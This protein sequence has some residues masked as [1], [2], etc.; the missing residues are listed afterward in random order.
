M[1]F[2]TLT[3]LAILSILPTKS[4]EAGA[5]ARVNS[6]NRLLCGYVSYAPALTKNLTT[7][8][9]EGFNADILQAVGKRLDLAVE[10]KVET[11]WATV[12]TDLAAGKFD[13]LCS[14][15][16]VHPNVGKYALFSRPFMFQPVF[17]VARADD[18][19][20][21]GPLN[22]NDPLLTMS[23]LD[24]DNPV[25]I[26]QA[27]FPKAKIM[28]LPNLTDFS[29]VLVSVATKK[30]DFTLVDAATFGAF[31]RYNKGKLR[32]VHV[33]KP[34][35]IYPVSYAFAADDVTLRDA[36]NAALDEMILDGSMDKIFDKY[37][38]FPH[39]YYRAVVPFKNTYEAK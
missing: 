17:L 36:V 23:A 25:N 7:G 8:V 22:L 2:I 1:R 19:R 27:D 5:L 37:N 34:V 18:A 33:D 20:F 16:W 15:F 32:L 28:T 10:F 30:A 13:M 21:D 38:E 24:G 9:W 39:A 29:E 11:G 35:R 12:A 3:L 14:G 6:T 31:D 4:A 26:A